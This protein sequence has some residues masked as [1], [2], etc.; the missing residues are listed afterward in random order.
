M[1]MREDKAGAGDMGV[2]R[3]GE[4]LVWSLGN[5][6]HPLKTEPRKGELFG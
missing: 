3:K 6:E 1:Q 4:G 2:E 5:S